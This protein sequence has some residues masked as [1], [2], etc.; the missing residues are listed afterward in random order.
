[1]P[2]TLR[3][4]PCLPE[5]SRL[6]YSGS[7]RENA[8]LGRFRGAFEGD[9]GSRRNITWFARNAASAADEA[10]RDDIGHVLTY[11]GSDLLKSRASMA[12]YLDSHPTVVLESYPMRSLGYAV[13]TECFDFYI[14][15]CANRGEYNFYIFCY[16]REAKESA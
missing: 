2:E 15:C 5:E 7:P 3:I 14:R 6:F 13:S 10:L 11:L 1:M 16:R 12:R 8:C 9:G 4:R